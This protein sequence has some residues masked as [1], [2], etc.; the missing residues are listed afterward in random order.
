MGKGAI[1]A[2]VLDA[3]GLIL[4]LVLAISVNIYNG[5]RPL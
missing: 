5:E 4:I 1:K 3:Q 2:K